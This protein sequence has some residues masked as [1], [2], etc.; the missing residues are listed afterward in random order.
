MVSPPGKD[1]HD[2]W[3]VYKYCGRCLVIAT[4][5]L[6]STF[7]FPTRPRPLYG[8]GKEWD[9]W[10]GLDYEAM[11]L[12]SELRWNSGCGNLGTVSNAASLVE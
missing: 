12:I 10:I 11:C 4:A 2:Q 1:Y 7:Q 6:S 8:S 9:G 5:R 3:A